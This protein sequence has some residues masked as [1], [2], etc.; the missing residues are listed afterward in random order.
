M[1]KLSLGTMFF[2]GLIC[3]NTSCAFSQN[4]INNDH[5][6]NMEHCSVKVSIPCWTAYTNRENNPCNGVC[7]LG[8]AGCVGLKWIR[9]PAEHFREP[10]PVPPKAPGFRDAIDI[11][12]QV[13]VWE[14]GCEVCIENPAAPSTGYCGQGTGLEWPLETHYRFNLET[15]C[16]G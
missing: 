3:F 14:I 15:A 6:I 16:R 2:V 5:P 10:V 7:E 9:V 12:P 4:P 11:T 13:C 8:G 1:L